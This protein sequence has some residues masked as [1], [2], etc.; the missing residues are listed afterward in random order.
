MILHE[1]IQ[2]FFLLFFSQP[3]LH[4]TAQTKNRVAIDFSLS[5]EIFGFG[6]DH[7]PKMTIGTFRVIRSQNEIISMFTHLP[8]THR[9]E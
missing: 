2:Q 9:I 7:F 1:K 3:I 4:F 5:V 6:L 8:I